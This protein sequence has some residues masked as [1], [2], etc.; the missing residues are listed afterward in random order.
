MPEQ[1]VAPDTPKKAIEDPFFV[2][3]DC[4]ELFQR[5]L[6][7][8]VKQSG[9][10]TPAEIEAFARVVGEAHDELAAAKQQDGFEQTA[11]L[12][13]SRIS[14]VGFDDLELD[15]RIGDIA[16]RL[17][18]NE[19]IDRWRVQ[20]R[21]MT[22]LNRP[23]MAAESS[24]VGLDPI[25]QGLWA[26]CRA[27]NNNLEQNL[28]RLGRLEEQ[29]QA[30]LPNVYT[31]LNDLLEHHGIE[32][33]QVQLMQR[34]TGGKP[35]SGPGFGG[36]GGDNFMPGANALANLQHALRQQFTSDDS[37]FDDHSPGN[38]S[39]GS[40]ALNA[41][42]LVMLNHL[43]ERLN[44]L[45]SQ[46]ASGVANGPADGG[47]GNPPLSALR[48]KDL[49]LPLG[50]PAAIALD[51]L[52]LIFEL[53]F[54]APDLPD[55]VK[56][57]IGRLQIPLLKLAILDASFF[58]DSRHPGRRLINRMARAAVGLAQDTG[59]EHPICTSLGKMADAVRTTLE[60]N[61]GDLSPHLD[62]LETLI[63]ERDQSL[64]ANARPYLQLLLGHEAREAA[65]ANAQDWLFKALGKTSH[66]Q[67]ARFLSDYWVRLMQLAFMEGGADGALW[68]EC[69][70]T[71]E[72]LLSSVRPQ[73]SAEER[74]QLL[75][76]I[77]SL[78]KSLNDGLDRLEISSTERTLFLNTC[79]HLQTAAL[80]NRPEMQDAESYARP[81][82]PPAARTASSVASSPAQILEG[83]GKRVRYLGLPSS[84]QSPW[85]SGNSAWKEGE[86]ISFQLPSGEHLCGLHCGQGTPTGTVLLF[87]DQWDYAVAVAPSLLEQQLRARI[88]SA[89]SLFDDAAERALSQVKPR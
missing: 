82:T 5:K 29:L 59:R 71:C 73:Q 48:S 37:F 58:A 35:A 26:I 45:E 41:S 54:A 81:V 17:K 84:V 28:E 83:D 6:V 80:R 49:D 10:M 32:P 79:F 1:T 21:Y 78:L 22:L 87:N 40:S 9:L 61:D 12:T 72:Q 75:A 23:N 56:A 16:N 27:G 62:E 89:S 65:I 20:L 69:A 76:L 38:A 30:Q 13:A 77:P 46:H 4:C 67:I 88:V 34:A 19:R 50:K 52:S 8:I 85:R 14:L 60:K 39:S 55:V 24:P 2:L 11:G 66:A 57:A 42:A 51:T 53:I 25:C 33:A 64:K 15:I 70:A 3:R 68:K 86:W 18:G 63:A 47:N 43:M 36:A 44:A 7:E 74:K 31:E